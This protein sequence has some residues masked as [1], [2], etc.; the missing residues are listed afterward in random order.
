L[1]V[2]ALFWFKHF[3]TVNVVQKLYRIKGHLGILRRNLSGIP[4]FKVRRELLKYSNNDKRTSI[5]SDKV[6]PNRDWNIINAKR[7]KE[8]KWY[9]LFIAISS[10]TAG[11]VSRRCE[12]DKYSY[13]VPLDPISGRCL[14]IRFLG[15]IFVIIRTGPQFNG[16]LEIIELSAEAIGLLMSIIT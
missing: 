9:I 7:R 4:I 6:G 8:T 14:L 11:A 1:H 5:T 3:L 16:W 10:Y 13:I 15:I 2:P 12:R